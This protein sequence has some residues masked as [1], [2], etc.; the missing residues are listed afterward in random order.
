M[1]GHCIEGWVGGLVSE[2]EVSR[3]AARQVSGGGNRQ[4]SQSSSWGGG[5]ERERRDGEG[6]RESQLWGCACQLLP[7]VQVFAGLSEGKEEDTEKQ[8]TSDLPST[9]IQRM[10]CVTSRPTGHPPPGMPDYDD[11][12]EDRLIIFLF[13]KMASRGRR[14]T[15]TLCGDQLNGRPIKW[16]TSWIRTDWHTYG[17]FTL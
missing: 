10:A 7:A 4:S 1:Q 12:C 2:W 6:V 16:G 8:E 9:W 11:L 5:E 3:D 14:D 17:V 13:L 15:L